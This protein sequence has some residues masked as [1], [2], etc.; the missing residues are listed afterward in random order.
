[1]ARYVQ[2]I[3]WPVQLTELPDSDGTLPAKAAGARRVLLD[4]QGAGLTSQALAELLAGWRDAGVRE[5]AFCIGGADGFAADEITSADQLL[6][7]GRAT[8]QHLLVR[9]M[10]AEQLYRATAII[11]GHPYHREGKRR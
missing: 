11:A 7:F 4:E 10:L 8:W 6:S 1:M 2:R 5:A 9:A 3:G